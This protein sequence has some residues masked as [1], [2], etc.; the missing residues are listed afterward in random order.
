MSELVGEV[1]NPLC[2][3]AGSFSSLYVPPPYASHVL[4]SNYY[5]NF[6]TLPLT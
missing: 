6:L 4:L 2:R 3:M 5:P 1:M